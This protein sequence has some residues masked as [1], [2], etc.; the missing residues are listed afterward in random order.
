MYSPGTLKSPQPNFSIL[1]ARIHKGLE[2]FANCE[3][4]ARY[5]GCTPFQSVDTVALAQETIEK[6]PSVSIFDLNDLLFP[7]LDSVKLNTWIEGGQL[8]PGETYYG[9]IH[10]VSEDLWDAMPA[11]IAK[12]LVELPTFEEVPKG[13]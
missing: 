11:R 5:P 7:E 2:Q 3:R 9:D 8:T 13:R 10:Y 6:N 12:E 4:Y 1:I